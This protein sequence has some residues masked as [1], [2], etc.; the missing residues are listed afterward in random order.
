MF[1]ICSGQQL[2]TL[3]LPTDDNGD[4]KEEAE[5]EA[6]EN[7]DDGGD[8]NQEGRDREEDGANE[9]EEGHDKGEEDESKNEV[10]VA[11]EKEK[12]KDKNI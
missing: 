2:I 6:K 9:T 8:E 3:S 5:E 1:R 7:G 4:M 11:E 12:P 10:E